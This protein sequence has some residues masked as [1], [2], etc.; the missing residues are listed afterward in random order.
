MVMYLSDQFEVHVA[1][2][3]IARSIISLVTFT[4]HRALVN[5]FRM[6]FGIDVVLMP[7]SI[8]SAAWLGF[9]PITFLSGSVK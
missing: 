4:F 7:W 6:R 9:M 2:R 3:A 5:S 8:P 1:N